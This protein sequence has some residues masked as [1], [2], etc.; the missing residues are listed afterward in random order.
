MSPFS[1][2]ELLGSF[3]VLLVW[4][5]VPAVSCLAFKN[6]IGLYLQT[7]SVNCVNQ[8][9]TE[10]AQAVSDI[11][12]D[13]RVLNI[14]VNKIMVLPQNG[15]KNLVSLEYLRLDRNKLSCIEPQAFWNLSSLR[16]LNLSHNYLES[17]HR[18]AFTSL[19]NLTSLS[20]QHNKLRDLSGDTVFPLKSLQ[21]LDISF[22]NFSNASS[23]IAALRR[24]DALRTLRLQNSSIRYLEISTS[25]PPRLSRLLLADNP[26]SRFRAP[27]D[28]FASIDHLDVSN[29][30]LSR[31]ENL[32][33]INLSGV[34]S[35][36]VGRNPL[37][38]AEVIEAVR[39]IK[40]P[41]TNISLSYLK[42]EKEQLR[43]LCGI[44]L[45][46]GIRS[47][48]LEGNKFKDVKG[49]FNR[50]NT[51][52]FLDMS[53]NKIRT[54]DIF[55][56]G[57]APNDLQ[58]LILDHNVIR[59]IS[60]CAVGPGG[61]QC[62]ST[63]PCLGKLRYLSLRYNRISAI[64]S[65]AFQQVPNLETLS[66]ALNGINFI[67]ISA[68]AGLSKLRFLSLTNNAIGEIFHATYMHVRNL[69]HLK[70]RNNRIPIIY[71]GYYSNLS[72][73]VTLDLGGNHIVEIRKGGFQGLRS[74]RR[75]YLDRNWLKALSADMFD[76]LQSLQ[77]LD[78]AQN[79]LTFAKAPDH[80]HPF[81]ALHSLRMLKLQRQ[82]TP[83]SMTLPPTL[84]D[85]LQRLQ[86]LDISNNKFDTLDT[87]PLH[88]LGGLEVLYMNN[89]YQAFGT[90]HSKTFA[91]LVNLRLLSLESAGLESIWEALFES[92]ASLRT[93]LLKGNKIG[94]VRN[95]DIL[96]LGNLSYLDLQD[97]LFA[98]V[99][100]N[101][102]FQQWAVKSKVQVPL[103]YGYS[104]GGQG[105]RKLLA[106]FDRLI[107]NN[108]FVAFCV[109]APAIFA[110]VATA[111]L[112]HKGK[113]SFYY[114]YYLLRAW[115]REKQLQRS[116]S[117]GHQYDAF[118]SYNSKDE[119][120]VFDQLLPHLETEGP[121]FHRLCFHHRDFAVGK[122]IVENIVDAIYNSKKT[123][124][125]ISKNYLQSEWCSME[126]QVALYR[127]FDEYSDVLILVFLDEI[128]GHVLSS[129]HHLRKLL[130]KKTYISWP[131]D[132]AGQRLFWAKL[133]NALKS[134]CSA[135][136]KLMH[137][138]I[139]HESL[140]Y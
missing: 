127:L 136:G 119:G 30:S 90:M 54:P 57:G 102:W 38:P 23:V 31:A 132:D 27:A 13:T 130:R 78:L 140:L 72:R 52:S 10:L 87:L 88:Q 40:A 85:G 121:P 45:K 73:L 6:C 63:A 37:A 8:G 67:N 129:Y 28:F 135:S 84:F 125:V 112:Y 120:W 99:C 51:I 133:R 70:L 65:H 64:M 29:C 109:S 34:H 39:N 134:D 80:F 42:L 91:N 41:L 55:T 43:T 111:L 110:F 107:C 113:W 123:L 48:T 33:S 108:G 139:Q 32:T 114:S 1:G 83:G 50:C 101:L 47:V 97:N 92:L 66:L 62:N 17:L 126:M 21:I 44:L 4:R 76:D 79:K 26:L 15:L 58:T 116:H 18:D 11:P 89:V 105:E 19:P 35:L 122:P 71:S 103:F 60:L 12:S 9:I 117:R 94:V 131:A 3:L 68:F 53:H 14:S 81:L 138:L 25:F 56:C 128:P 137:P 106:Q 22:N 49:V 69:E 96:Q 104:C 59:D 124:C 7:R 20:L 16:E 77:V 100:E 5:G 115:V 86:I 95:K 98:C 24:A 93:L 46:R 118:V 61:R 2:A 82:D 36:S 75:L 74:L